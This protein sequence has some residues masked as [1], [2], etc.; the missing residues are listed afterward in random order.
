MSEII[1]KLEAKIYNASVEN[2]LLNE[3]VDKLENDNRL[4]YL[5]MEQQN[6]HISAFEKYVDIKISILKTLLEAKW[7]Y[8]K[9]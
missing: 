1:D 4:L 9:S 2:E 6:K 5:Q 7:I 8:I 3:R